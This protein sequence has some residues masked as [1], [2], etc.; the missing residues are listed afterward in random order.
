[1]GWLDALRGGIRPQDVA[2]ADAELAE[3][4]AQAA[5]EADQDRVLAAAQEL[6]KSYVRDILPALSEERAFGGWGAEEIA[7]AA[8]AERGGG[9][10][11][12]YRF[13]PLDPNVYLPPEA[14]PTTHPGTAGVDFE[15]LRRM[16]RHPV[17][18]AVIGT[19]VNQI[20]EFALPQADAYSLG[21][22]IVQKDRAKAAT[23]ATK[24]R[25]AEISA[26]I[27]TCGDPGISGPLYTFEAFLRE[28]VRDSLIFDQ[29]CFEVVPTRDGK[30]VSGFFAVDAS[31]IRRAAL[32]REELAAG[33][34]DTRGETAFVQIVQHKVVARF[35]PD[36]L[37][38]GV[39][40]PRT[41]I[42][43]NGY[44]Y[45]ELEEL[46][47]TLARI[48]AAELYNAGNFSNGIHASGL[49]AVMSKMD[50][51]SWGAFVRDF[52]AMLQG[53][54]NAHK[55]P[56]LQLD[57]S[58]KE[59]IKNVNLS[60]NNKEM[61]F[62]QW[63][64]WLI[65][66]ATAVY[67]MDP[68]ELNFVFGNEGQ[69]SAMSGG[70]PA[71]RILA[72]K[73]RGLRPTLRAVQTWINAGIVARVDPDYELEF[74]GLDA[75]D[76]KAR[77]DADGK[78][79]KTYMTPNEVRARHDLDRIDDPAADMILDPTYVSASQQAA[80]AAQQQQAAPPEGN[81]DED[82]TE[83]EEEYELDLG[84]DADEPDEELDFGGLF[85]DLEK[86]FAAPRVFAAEVR[87]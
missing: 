22:R 36:R 50:K 49:I 39:R 86:A 52:R 13:D 87:A 6:A 7:K 73:E 21:Y 62:M 11:A 71:D 42:R 56:I 67:Q 10:G 16:A 26:W 53:P 44:G 1:M 29:G 61:E 5:R 83:D 75:D 74:V 77:V 32:T 82:G 17:F 41:D 66:I 37:V 47:S 64:G 33:R 30:G 19:R 63:L 8:R 25:A 58:N 81:A 55:T 57:P 3:M 20:A 28:L 59:D 60:Q 76:E 4:R 80:A 27:Q 9:Q 85:G 2:Q 48:I 54:A 24:A 46:I 84:M 34:R 18:S 68:A 40:R 15:T 43:A 23:K 45:P 38:F 78:A 35:P 79:V 65:K 14:Q 51:A 31:T 70:G 69:R 72:S 12:A